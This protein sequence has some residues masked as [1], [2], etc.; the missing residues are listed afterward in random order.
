VP[1]VT[2]IDRSGSF[3]PLRSL[4]VVVVTLVLSVSGC[5]G[6]SSSSGSIPAQAQTARVRFLDGAPS[7]ETLIGGVP[8]PICPDPSNPCYLQ[9]NKQTVTQGFYYGSM[10]SFTNVTAGALS[11][12]AR[13]AAGYAVGPL[14]T[15][16]LS[17]GKQYTLIVVGSYPKYQVLAFEEPA[18]SGSA[19]LSLY[20]AAPS[21]PQASFGTFRAS[22]HSNFTKRGSARFGELATVSLGKSVTDVGGYV[23]NAG[24]PIGSVTPSQ[25]DSFDRRNALPY[26]NIARLSLF[27]FDAKSSSGVGAVF[28]SL[29][30]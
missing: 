23:G 11:L 17:P 8:Q 22:T 1:P 12:V 27:L 24:S 9:V 30:R 26:H 25:I 3:E 5:G 15:T 18:S 7:L 29:D 16:A 2:T 10:T 20:N 28:G 4:L 21:T 14:T 6:S 13:V 19:A